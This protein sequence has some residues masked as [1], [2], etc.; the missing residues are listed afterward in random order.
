MAY[1]RKSGMEYGDVLSEIEM[2]EC[3]VQARVRESCL[4]VVVLLRSTLS[5]RSDES[6]GSDAQTAGG[7]EICG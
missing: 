5:V 7:N 6:V 3:G 2:F 4:D 1:P